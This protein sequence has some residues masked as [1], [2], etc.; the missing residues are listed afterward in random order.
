MLLICELMVE[1]KA[2]FLKHQHV[3]KFRNGVLNRH[4]PVI[5]DIPSVVF[6]QNRCYMREQVREY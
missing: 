5:L 6:F 4:V 2:N 3:E 1:Q